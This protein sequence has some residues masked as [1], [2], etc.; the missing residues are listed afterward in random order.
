M[1]VQQHIK[2]IIEMALPQH[3]I[4]SEE[5]AAAASAEYTRLLSQ[6]TPNKFG[7][8]VLWTA[9]GVYSLA[10]Y[11]IPRNADY[12][13]VMRVECYT[14]NL[15]AGA[16]D[17]GFQQPPPPGA[18]YWELTPSGTGTANIVSDETMQS[19]VMLD[20]DEQRFF[21]AGQTIT[22]KGDFNVSPD[23]NTRNVRTLVY[24]YNVSSEIMER[25][26]GLQINE[27][28]SSGV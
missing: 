12:T 20:C 26:G 10:S 27:P 14:V 4:F 6:I 22:L 17:Y 3:W 5:A 1:L 2:Q 7:N 21:Q 28:P 19:H 15:T 13:I 8:T 11:Q 9:A 16:A 25:I 18:A 24:C 23:G